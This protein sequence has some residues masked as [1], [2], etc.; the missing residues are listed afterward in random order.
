[1]RAKLSASPRKQAVVVEGLAIE[2]GYQVKKFRN[3]SENPNKDKIKQFYYRSDIVY[4]MPGKGD[5][6]TAWNEEGKQKLRKYY[7]TMYL[8]E[9]YALYLET[10]EN[11]N[12]KCNF[13]TFCNLR[14]KTVLL[15]VDSPKEQCKCQIHENFFSS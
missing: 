2:Y 1:M 9:A 13:S 5:E 10:C 12:E 14:P 7:L 8:K 6:M 4:T 3:N 15:L 11:D